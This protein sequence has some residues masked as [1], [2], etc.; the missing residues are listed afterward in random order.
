M[1]KCSANA[2]EQIWKLENTDDLMRYLAGYANLKND[3]IDVFK[4]NNVKKVCDAA[5]GF[6]AYSLAFATNGFEVF[7]FDISPTAVRITQ[8]GLCKYGI[9]G[10]RFKIASI[11]DTG[12]FDG[13]F[14][15]V[16]AHAVI[17]H[18]T[19]DDAKRAINELLRISTPDGLICISFD[20][21]EHDDFECEHEMIEDGTMLYKEGSRQGLIFH[22]Y[23][24]DEI[25]R[26][27][28]G[29]E[30]IYRKQNSKDEKVVIIKNHTKL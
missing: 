15:G 12:Y 26:L 10:A 28:D 13:E 17:D 14:D 30:M 7:G 27:F 3:I 24:W 22:P 2:W 1:D 4:E 19:S 5:C 16:I 23:E 8:S 11:L 6:G 9:D 25:D 20:S 21:A 29:F 18:L